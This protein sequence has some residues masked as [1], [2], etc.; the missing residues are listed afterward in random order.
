[1]VSKEQILKFLLC[2]GVAVLKK[3]ILPVSPLGRCGSLEKPEFNSFSTLQG[4]CDLESP[5]FNSF[6]FGRV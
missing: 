4:C 1:M 6:Y 3:L 5:G 2:E